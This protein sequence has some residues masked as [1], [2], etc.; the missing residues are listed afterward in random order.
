[1]CTHNKLVCV[2]RSAKIISTHTNTNI[3]SCH[4]A[5]HNIPRKS[6]FT[7]K[8][9]LPNYESDFEKNHH[10]NWKTI[11]NSFGNKEFIINEMSLTHLVH[12]INHPHQYSSQINVSL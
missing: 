1:M 12:R 11:I 5:S 9:A 3:Y 7:V 4:T 8:F 2:S 6:I 10:D